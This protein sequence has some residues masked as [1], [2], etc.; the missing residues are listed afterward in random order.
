[1]KIHY[2][3]T[4]RDHAAIEASRKAIR[5][6]AEALGEPLNEEPLTFPPGASLHY[7]GTTRMGQTNDGES[8]CGPT[9]E[10]WDVEGLYVAGN[11]VI[12]T[13]IACNPTLLSV[14]LAV[15]GAS[16]IANRLNADRN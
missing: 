12:P 14:A 11:G 1:M 7:Q 9:S 13:S 15:A 16:S 5:R 3:L 6:A 2:R 4:E 10:V 8:V